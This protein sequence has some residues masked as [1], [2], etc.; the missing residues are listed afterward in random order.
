MGRTVWIDMESSTYVEGTIEL[1]ATLLARSPNTGLCMQAYLHRTWDDVQKL[2]P[3][4]PTI[5]LVKGAYREPKDV[6]FQDKRVIDESYF[7]LATHLATSARRLAL[8]THDT[9]LI[10]RTRGVRGGDAL[11]HPLGRAT[12]TGTRRVHRADV[13]RVWPLLVSV[14][15]EAHRRETGREHAPCAT[16]RV[17]SRSGINSAAM[18]L[19]GAIAAAV[20]PMR[21][22]GRHV[23]DEAFAPL[24][25]YLVAG[26]V[27]GLL[28]CGTTG[29][30][31]LL[32]VDERR[33]VAESF[34]AAR[35]DGFQVAVH[36][37]AQTTSDT[38][39]LA[40]HALDVGA[41]AVAVIA[42]PYFPL[43]AEELTRHFVQVADACDPLPFY[44]YEFAA[45]SGY[46]IPIEVIARVRERSPNLR[47]LKV[48]DT[49]FAAVEPYLAVEGMDVFVGN[50][51]LVLDGMERG[52]IGAVS[53]LATAFPSITAALVHDR[54][55]HA[56]E[57]VQRLRTGLQGIPFHA[58]MKE[59][60][61]ASDVLKSA[62]VRA[63]LRGLT[64][65]ER[66][67]VL[68]LARE[69][70]ASP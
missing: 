5:R 49:P 38:V 22:G 12:A 63:P 32:S 62:D 68:A 50:E 19:R 37:G 35:P 27:D 34:L 39:V 1:Y 7:R 47:G 66:S 11:R 53:G 29:E 17:L 43:D 14:V 64:D 70:E 54:S 2:A 15:H 4:D 41:D 51:P 61:V 56:G 45:R 52:A 3:L 42:P 57:Q 25:R 60:L 24:V 31:M 28:A 23:D 67:T 9:D 36:T 40:A 69:V 65:D 21:D 20:T 44:L 59:A 26:G 58:A 18:G 16:E 13:D 46:A 8:G 6:A 48:S 55:E 10:A 30:G 33:R